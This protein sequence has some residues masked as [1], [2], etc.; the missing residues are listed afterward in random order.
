MPDE[1]RLGT[2]LTND[3]TRLSYVE[4]GEGP[5]LL[6]VA[7]WTM[8]VE[9]WRHQI[10]EFSRTHHV[11]A[12]DHR[13]HGLSQDPGHGYR[14]SRLAADA[15]DVIRSLG[16]SD[17]TWVGH[18]MGCAVAWAYWDLFGDAGLGRLV[19]IDEPPVTVG[20]PDWAPEAATEA[21]AIQDAAEA[22][23]FTAALR[24]P[25]HDAVRAAVVERMTSP[26]LADTDRARILRQSGLLRPEPASVLLL[27]HAM[28]D[29]RDVLPRITVPVLVIGGE[30]SMF[31]A[32]SFKN[33]VKTI[34]D[35]QVVLIPEAD[36]GSHLAFYENPAAV[37]AAIRDF[38][39][40]Q[41]GE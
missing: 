7:G 31:P 25:A 24:G 29:W 14:V 18:S 30:A 22:A 27:D 34:P 9:L 26:G 39:R 3:G 4:A 32:A 20:R 10:A 36:R 11:V 6:L 19:L 16:L 23:G 17:V 5:D 28:A 33:M 35:S 8:T 38:L 13:G 41:G 21:G 40:G 15:R 1:V 2:L 12:Y 37:N